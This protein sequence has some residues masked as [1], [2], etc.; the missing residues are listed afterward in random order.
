MNFK[1]ISV[2]KINQQKGKGRTRSM[3]ANRINKMTIIII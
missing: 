1:V 3:K 2:L